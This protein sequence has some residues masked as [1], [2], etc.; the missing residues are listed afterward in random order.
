MT[1]VGIDI[2]SHRVV[3]GIDIIGSGIKTNLN[4]SKQTIADIITKIDVLREGIVGRACL[5]DVPH[6]LVIGS[7]SLG[8]GV[9]GV[10]FFDSGT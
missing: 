1:T 8:V 5:N 3:L 6:V 7:D 10:D 2:S 4:P 9:V